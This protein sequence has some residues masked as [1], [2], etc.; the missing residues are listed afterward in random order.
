MA[1]VELDNPLA[2]GLERLPVHPTNIVIFGAT[3]DLAR[4]KLLPAVYN[5]AHEGALPQRFN[6]VGVSRAEMS[7]AEYRDEAAEAIR[8][9]SRTPPDDSVLEGLLAGLRY[10]T[11][12]FGDTPA[13][14]RLATTLKELDAAAVGRW[15]ASSTCRPRPSSSL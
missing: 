3:G 6:L 12:A 5:L 9:F 15:T 11:L 2:E 7:D 13:Y 8:A 4:R 1:T 14:S 10:V